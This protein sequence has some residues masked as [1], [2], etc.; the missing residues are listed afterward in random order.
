MVDKHLI[1]GAVALVADEEKVLDTEAVGFSS[2]RRHTPMRPDDLFWI[3]SMSKSITATAFMMLVDEGKVNIDDPVEKYLPEFKGQ[4]VAEEGDKDHPHP[5]K[6]PITVKEILSH[7]SGLIKASDPKATRA[8]VLKDNVAGYASMPLLREP[9]T[10]YEYNNCGISTAGR[11]IEV[12]SGVPYADFVQQRLFDPLEMK[13]TTFW[14]T[15]E[16]ASRLAKSARFTADKSD[17][18]E[19][20][21]EKG[22]TPAGIA[23]FG[24]GVPVPH[25]ILE[26]FG[27]GILPTY[28]HHFA[29]PAGGLF[30]TA[31]DLGNFCQM[32]LNGGAWHGKRLLSE[33]AVRQ[34]GSNQTGDILVSPQEA[35]GLGWMIKLK[36]DEGP[37]IGS[38]GHRGAR[39]T[40]MWVDPTNHLAMVLLFERFD[41]PG[42]AQEQ[43]YTGVFGAAVKRYGKLSAEK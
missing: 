37:S 23:K 27:G 13:D 40:A 35:Y 42:D 34:M 25:E 28:A 18:E 41:M 12:L 36:A 9:G 32:L 4:R 26:D 8:Y 17:L 24:G 2:L 33:K 14:P 3:A 39:R 20:Q 31:H 22:L 30:S 21:L 1:A 43:V 15:H 11:I 29:E 10:K 19:L 7:T 38:F 5:P 6:H 16:Q